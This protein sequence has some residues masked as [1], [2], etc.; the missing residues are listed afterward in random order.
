[1]RQKSCSPVDRGET[2]PVTA[3]PPILYRCRCFA[4]IAS[5][6][7]LLRR[8]VGAGVEAV[9]GPGARGDEGDGQHAGRYPAGDATG[10]DGL[11]C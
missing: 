10:N 1:M 8:R 11:A 3:V 6:R 4:A 2:L 7:A 5:A 9:V